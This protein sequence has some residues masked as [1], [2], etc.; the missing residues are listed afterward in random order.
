MAAYLKEFSTHS[1]YEQYIN[2]SGA[3]LPNVSICKTE[4]DVHYNPDP[5]AGHEYVEIGGLKWAT[6]N[7]GA[8]SITDT[9]LYFQW[10]D[11]SGYTAE[12]VGRDEGQKFFGWAD[13]K[14]GSTDMTKYQGT[15]EGKDG[16][17]VLE[18]SDDAARANWGGKWRMPTRTEFQALSTA[19]TSAWTDDYQ[20]SGVAGLIC[21]DK[22]DSSKVLFFPAAGWCSLGN[23]IE[24][25]RYGYYWSS[26]LRSSSVQNAYELYFYNGDV[27]W[28]HYY[29][30]CI[31]FPVRGVVN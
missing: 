7:V 22:T 9:G 16:K 5:Y 17:T 28:Q 1:E 14:Y 30:R 4:G 25:G 29:N 24:V 13:Y 10:G 27:Y 2:G 19:T 6:M 18:V 12:Q 20:G 15:G 3:I 26:S 11:I 21:T 8:N 31:G 23:V